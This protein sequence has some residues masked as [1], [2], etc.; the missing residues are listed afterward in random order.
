MTKNLKWFLAFSLLWSTAFFAVLHSSLRVPAGPWLRIGAAGPWL[1]VGAAAV[2][3]GIGFAVLGSLLGR[4][5]A[6]SE[7]RYSL[8]YAYAAVG[9]IASATV[10]VLWIV[11]FRPYTFWDTVP[12][13]SIIAVFTVIG[14]I[15]ARRSIKGMS[16][17]VLFR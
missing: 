7:V 12:Y 13:L 17:S 14:A 3:Y 16:N 15:Q 2:I 11:F 10:G 9:N 4:G 6:Q 1:Q 8:G 5:D